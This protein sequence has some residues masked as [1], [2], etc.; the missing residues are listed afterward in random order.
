MA[1]RQHSNEELQV[2][3]GVEAALESLRDL[4]RDNLSTSRLA[5]A[6]AESKIRALRSWAT[7]AAVEETVRELESRLGQYRRMDEDERAEEL[8]R[9]AELI[10]A[11]RPELRAAVTPVQPVGVLD[12]AISA[13]RVGAREPRPRRSTSQAVGPLKPDDPITMLPGVGPSVAKK[14]ATHKHTLETVGDLLALPPIRHLD[15]SRTEPISHAIRAVHAEFGRPSGVEVTIRGQITNLETLAHAK[16]PRTVAK[17]SDGTGWVRVTWFSGYVGRQ[18]SLGDEIVIAGELKQEFGTHGFT[19]PEW[20]LAE[21]AGLST[22]RLVPVYPL[23]RGVTQKTLRTLTRHA[24][25]ATRKQLYDALPPDIRK[26]YGLLPLW[27]AY[28]AIHYPDGYDENVAGR[29]RLAFDD[30]FFLQLGYLM[31][32]RDRESVGGI[33]LDVK[34]EVL[35]AFLEGLPFRLTGAQRRVL[36][37]IQA[38]VSQSVPM[39]RLLQGDVGS[40]K[41][42][43]AAAAALIATTNGY[44]AAV[45]APT[46][47]LA[48]QHYHNLRGLLSELPEVERPR[49]A[50][51][52]GSTKAKE[53]RQTLASV[54]TGL[55]DILVGTHALI[56]SQVEFE[57]LAVAVVDEQHRFGVRQRGE[58]SEKGT[59]A[60]PHVLAMTATPIPRTLNLVLHGDL[61]V[62]VLDELPPGRIPIETRRYVG[63]EREFAYDLIRE[64]VD[65]GRQVFVICPLVE[66]SEAI[67]AKAATEEA[68]RLQEDV[69][70]DL[71][72]ALLHGRMSAKQKDEVMTAFRDHEFDILVSTSVIEVGIDVP[73][74]TV[75]MIEGADRFGLAQL[76]QFRGRVGRGGHR[77]YCLLLADDLSRDGDERLQTMV[78]SDDGFVLAQRDLELRGPG[79][80]LGT[81]QSGLPELSWLTEGFDT[82]VLDE[83]RRAAELTLAEDP[84][85]SLPEHKML[86][87]EL[88]H[89]W[90]RSG[91]GLAP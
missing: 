59:E 46:E 66:E 33:A 62:S 64:Q 30:L 67:E 50:L 61:E 39:S 72:I 83:A 6:K 19:N 63:N 78:E 1:T 56:Q 20:E 32:R 34:T 25:D 27:D 75:M 13:T 47:I 80:F 41:T 89:F 17:V 38:D 90:E 54:Q 10:K 86:K 51:L 52:T 73:N 81:R 35:E 82:R 55:V 12:G 28:E 22:G 43:L 15:F 16:P 70:P 14:L 8:K 7:S 29:R 42:V 31:R 65:L 36:A 68:Q 3:R 58:L 60:P 5:V 87:A 79:D 53:R 23:T 24:L 11:L 48:E 4:W 21:K 18:L 45:M 91:V 2:D 88:N 26:E 71:R 74:A 37:E 40:G 77:S 49:V 84:D 69:F 85:L 76:H 44:Q 9:L 57:K